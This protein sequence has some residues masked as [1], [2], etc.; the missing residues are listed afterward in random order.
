MLI[1]AGSVALRARLTSSGTADLIWASLPIYAVAFTG[2]GA[3]H[4]EAGTGTGCEPGA[5]DFVKRGALAFS[6]ENSRIVIAW[7]ATT[8]AGST[9]IRLPMPCNVWAM[10]LDDVGALASVQPGERIAV[11]VAES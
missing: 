5:S 3:I 7:A 11:L 8:V 1:R 4:F 2:S 10:A 9:E 6:S